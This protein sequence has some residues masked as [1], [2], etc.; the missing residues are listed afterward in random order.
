MNENIKTYQ[1]TMSPSSRRAWIEI[2]F[3]PLCELLRNVALLA[4]GVDRNAFAGINIYQ[5]LAE[6]PSSRRAWIEMCT[7]CHY[8]SRGY[9]ALLAEGVDRNIDPETDMDALAEGRPPRGG[10][11]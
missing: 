4:E 10:R 11:G 1:R 6:S 9:V 2:F 5:V 7:P 3:H 8:G